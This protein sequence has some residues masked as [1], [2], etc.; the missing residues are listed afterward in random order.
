MAQY[1]GVISNRD[2]IKYKGAKRPF[3]EFLES[4]PDGWLMSLAYRREGLPDNTRMIFDCGAW[5]Y[6]HEEEPRLNGNLVT[7]G[8][9]FEQYQEL[10]RPGD[11]L[12]A[13]D[14]ML[15][16]GV[17]LDARRAFNQD[18]AARFLELAKSSPYRPMASVH[19]MTL[20]ERIETA[21]RYVAMGYTALALGGLAAR[22]SQK[23][24]ALEVVREVR[25]AVP[26][27]W[28]HVLGLSAP[29][30]AAAWEEYG[31][32]SFD[33]SSHFKAAFTGDFY[34]L[35]DGGILQKHDASRPG[36]EVTA[37]LCGCWACSLLGAE[38]IDTRCYGSNEH[39]M[40]RA[41]HNMN[42]LMQAQQIAVQGTTVL[43]SC[44]G[45]KLSHAAPAADLYQ[46]A[47][48]RKARTYAEQVSKRWYIL[49]A[50][51]GLLS[52][53]EIVEPYEVTLNSMPASERKAWAKRTFKQIEQRIPAGKVVI[54]AGRRYREHLETML[55]EAGYL[56]SIPL[57]GL[58][59][60]Q[61]LTWLMARTSYQPRLFAIE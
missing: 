39:N 58:G 49:S 33:G 20:P 8:W 17:D 28:L 54:L 11:F 43:V 7:P 4:Q 52:P 22:A 60:G 19:G 27:V 38:G 1:F 25:K 45:Q 36:E 41:A 15:I 30:Y 34:A 44:V 2:Y 55:R 46:S 47:W 42:V 26:S 6:R 53:G 31:I 32:Q 57:A 13:P 37:P 10:A 56:V 23:S 24:L 12:L 51:H 9:A 14:H 59:I 48:F 21:R 16:P 40:G 50:K 3:W 35:G 61:Q 29:D 18:S 5:T